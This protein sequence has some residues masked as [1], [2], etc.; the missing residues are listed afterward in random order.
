ML[1][2]RTGNIIFGEEEIVIKIT[3]IISRDGKVLGTGIHALGRRNEPG[4][5]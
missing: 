5:S 1:A 4:S 2:V 3:R